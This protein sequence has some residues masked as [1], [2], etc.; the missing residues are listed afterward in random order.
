VARSLRVVVAF[1]LGGLLPLVAIAV[2]PPRLRVP[3]TVAA[4]LWRLG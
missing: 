1:A 4:V 3:V 2:P